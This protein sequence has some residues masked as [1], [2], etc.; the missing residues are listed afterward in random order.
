MMTAMM[1]AM[2][3]T[4]NTHESK[5]YTSSS[6]S[7]LTPHPNRPRAPPTATDLQAFRE[8]DPAV[9]LGQCAVQHGICAPS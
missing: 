8:Q 9:Y 2:M 5:K 1:T 3:T 6:H 4:L 7:G